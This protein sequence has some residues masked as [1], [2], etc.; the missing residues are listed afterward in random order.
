MV[1]NRIKI[2]VSQLCT[3]NWQRVN[4]LIADPSNQFVHS[5]TS[6]Q[7]SIILQQPQYVLSVQ[8][9]AKLFAQNCAKR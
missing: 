8:F 5:N 3:L 2:K 9:C 7:D 1:G 6:T 4:A